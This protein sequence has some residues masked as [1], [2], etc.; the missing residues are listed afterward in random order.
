MEV[1]AASVPKRIMRKERRN[2]NELTVD[3]PLLL[4]SDEVGSATAGQTRRC[5]P[6]QKDRKS[7]KPTYNDQMSPQEVME[8]C[9]KDN[10]AF[11]QRKEEGEAK[12]ALLMGVADGMG[13]MMPDV[14]KAA[15]KSS[16][17]L[18]TFLAYKTKP[19]DP[20]NCQE[21]ANCQLY[22]KMVEGVELS[23]D[24]LGVVT[25]IDTEVTAVK[26]D[27]ST[28][29]TQLSANLSRVNA[30]QQRGL[31]RARDMQMQIH[32]FEAKLEKR[33][34][35]NLDALGSIGRKLDRLSKQLTKLQLSVVQNQYET[36][37]AAFMAS[38]AKI[39][40]AYDDFL[41]AV[42]V[43]T[44]HAATFGN[45][46][47]SI[48]SISAFRKENDLA[49]DSGRK[50]AQAAW[51]QARDAFATVAYQLSDGNFLAVH[52]QVSVNAAI[53]D[54]MNKQTA[55]DKCSAVL[56][57]LDG[58]LAQVRAQAFDADLVAACFGGAVLR[59]FN[60]W[61][62]MEDIFG[63]G[64]VPGGDLVS[65]TKQALR[66]FQKVKNEMSQT[67][68]SQ[69]LIKST[70][71]LLLPSECPFI[72]PDCTSA[73]LVSKLDTE[74]AVRINSEVFA[75]NPAAQLWDGGT[76]AGF[77]RCS[78]KPSTYNP[79]AHLP[80]TFNIDSAS[81]ERDCKASIDRE[82]KCSSDYNLRGHPDTP[83]VQPSAN[84]VWKCSMQYTRCGQKTC[85]QW[86]SQ[87]S[88]NYV[89]DLRADAVK[90]VIKPEYNFKLAAGALSI[91][92]ATWTKQVDGLITSMTMGIGMSGGEIYLKAS[93][94][95]LYASRQEARYCSCATPNA[96]IDSKKNVYVCD[97]GGGSECYTFQRRRRWWNPP[98][99]P[100]YCSATTSVPYDYRLSM[101]CSTAPASPTPSPTPSP[102]ACSEEPDNAKEESRS[103]SSVWGDNAIGTGHAQSMLDS[104]KS[105]STKANEVGQWMQIDLG[106]VSAVHGIVSQGRKEA[107]QWVTTYTVTVSVDAQSWKALGITFTG[108]SDRNTK[109]VTRFPSER[110]ARYVRIWPQ[111]WRGHM[112]MRA[113]VLS[114]PLATMT[115]SL[116]MHTCQTA[117][118]Q[119]DCQWSFEPSPW[120]EGAY[121]IRTSNGATYIEATWGAGT[122]KPLSTRT[123]PKEKDLPNC[124][125]VLEQSASRKGAYYI[126]AAEGATYIQGNAGGTGTSISMAMLTMQLCSKANNYASCQWMLEVA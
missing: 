5:L 106:V 2:S 9:I 87:G 38:I 65:A 23:R 94:G 19:D 30:L 82:I 116:K 126:R 120:R 72:D 7:G 3:P 57:N 50:R 107:D 13:E 12:E 80:T 97:E 42:A 8:K 33:N 67:K 110:E 46:K 88:Q 86:Y 4:Q 51:S 69:A 118:N 31:S 17:A 109:V 60:L 102:T 45:I 76:L 74:L 28:L 32:V 79:A 35:E 1:S 125:W 93:D 111:T 59:T 43:V 85:K 22:E 18:A 54:Y 27:V 89:C 37:A 112:S 98:K 73:A 66:A 48:A 119:L 24:I 100:Q 20:V 21:L 124:Q 11:N 90:A 49:V 71:S 6:D 92:T 101:A 53:R 25:G 47:P 114:C 55:S 29:H 99:V 108:N 56:Q 115:K 41:S 77:Y 122:G 91:A 78:A 123:C 40:G 58:L 84:G 36:M 113:G 14:G 105:W 121:Y 81:G 75:L 44:N 16:M 117:D 68:S 15:L 96:G 70:L 62:G 10:S 39:S 61:S 34:G 103:Y 52:Y 26:N 83:V 64:S 63:V 104:A 95:V